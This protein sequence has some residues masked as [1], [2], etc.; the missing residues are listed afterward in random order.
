MPWAATQE[1]VDWVHREIRANGD[2]VSEHFEE[3]IP[4]QE[5]LEGKPFPEEFTS[6]LYDRLNHRR[7]GDR[8]LLSLNA[9]DPLRRALAPY[10]GNKENMPLPRPWSSYRFNSPEV[11]TAYARY[12]RRMVE[13]FNP[14]YL[15]IGVETNLLMRNQ[16]AKWADYIEL[17]SSTYQNI[18]KTYAGPVFV[19]V[20]AV[21]LLGPSYSE[22]NADDQARALKDLLPYCDI[23]GVSLHP[24]MSSFLAERVP[25]E[26]YDRVFELAPGKK[27]AITE[28]SYPARK[29]STRVNG[30]LVEFTGTDE[31]QEAFLSRLLESAERHEAP[32][33]IWFTIRDYDALWKATGKRNDLL[34]WRD[35][36]LYD[37]SGSARKALGT[38]K[39]WLAR[40]YTA[41]SQSR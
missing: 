17:L 25:E 14:D 37:E 31:K 3:G 1:A 30:T 35:T 26:L 8:L 12:V 2:I 27:V 33:A 20:E 9:M 6:F 19:T 13:L 10:R 32:F 41:Q 39:G 4:W 15:A 16:P 7:K 38:W 18:K 29:W 28:A 24:F 40:K 22:A 11:K 36:G 21:A 23:L 5:A 34:I